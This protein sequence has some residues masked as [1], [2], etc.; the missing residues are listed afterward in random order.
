MKVTR[1]C[2]PEVP[3]TLLWETIVSKRE[4]RDIPCARDI[5]F[6]SYISHQPLY[7]KLLY[8]HCY[9]TTK[10]ETFPAFCPPDAWVIHHTVPLLH[11]A[12][13]AIIIHCQTSLLLALKWRLLPGAVLF[14]K[15]CKLNI[16]WMW[17][18]PILVALGYS[19]LLGFTP[20]TPF[21]V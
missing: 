2:S 16:T 14:V 21:Q 7:S 19:C 10:N 17:I 3:K 12:D 4:H 1:W 8:L 11:E 13:F 5:T 6:C 18:F 9:K 15:N 20:Q